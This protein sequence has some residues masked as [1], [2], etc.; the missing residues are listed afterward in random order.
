MN[1]HEQIIYHNLES[2]QEKPDLIL[3]NKILTNAAGNVVPPSYKRRIGMKTVLIAAVIAVVTTTTAFA[4]GEEIV[5]VIRRITS[6]NM[7]AEQVADLIPGAGLGYTMY[8]D[9][10]N[11]VEEIDMNLLSY[12]PFIKFKTLEEAKE[13]ASFVINIPAFLPE[14]VVLYNIAVNQSAHHA[15]L[16]YHK[17]FPNFN[18]DGSEY[19]YPS[20]RH[21]FIFQIYVGPD[22]YLDI[23]TTYPLDTVMVGDIEAF[24]LDR[25]ET[26]WTPENKPLTI[27]NLLWIKDGIFYNMTL[28]S[29]D[30]LNSVEAII[31]IAESIG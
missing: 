10:I 20:Y 3:R 28:E 17:E 25:T 29:W 11:P 19:I 31:A 26:I 16:S 24:L 23:K 27:P 21:L 30:G 1:N 4:N 12:G 5:G 13:N 22:A 15:V 7:V 14:G 8:F 18:S 9:I 6:G 2:L